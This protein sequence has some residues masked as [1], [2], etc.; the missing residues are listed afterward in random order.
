MDAKAPGIPATAI[1][2]VAR[3]ARVM[4][5]YLAP[6]PAAQRRPPAPGQELGSN[7]LGAFLA[8]SGGTP[9]RLIDFVSVPAI[10]SKVNIAAKFNIT[11]GG[12]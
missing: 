2:K 7:S 11:V 8:E 3:S 4:A 1:P 5:P 12:P 6:A 10:S 9:A